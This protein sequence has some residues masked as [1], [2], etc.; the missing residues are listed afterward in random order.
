MREGNILFLT[1]PV[2]WS[3]LGTCNNGVTGNGRCTACEARR[4][5]VYCERSGWRSSLLLDWIQFNVGIVSA[6][7]GIVVLW[8]YHR[9][10]TAVRAERRYLLAN[11]DRIQQF[12]SA[13]RAA[14]VMA[15]VEKKH[16]D[17]E[18]A[19][20]DAA[21]P[22]KT[23]KEIE[24]DDKQISANGS[25]DEPV[26]FFG[27]DAEVQDPTI[28]YDDNDAAVVNVRSPAPKEQPRRTDPFD[29]DVVSSARLFASNSRSRSYDPNMASRAHYRQ[30]QFDTADFGSPFPRHYDSL[31]Q[32]PSLD[33][34]NNHSH[35]VSAVSR[36]CGPGGMAAS[37]LARSSS[38]NH[39]NDVDVSFRRGFESSVASQDHPVSTMKSPSTTSLRPSRPSQHRSLSNEQLVATRSPQ[40]QNS[41][42]TPLR[43]GVD[44]PLGMTTKE[45]LRSPSPMPR[46][47]PGDRVRRNARHV[48]ALCDFGG[49]IGDVL[50]GECVTIE[51]IIVKRDLEK[52]VSYSFTAVGG[53]QEP[54][55]PYTL[56]DLF[57]IASNNSSSNESY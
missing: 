25:D 8:V 37:Q 40:E 3:V 54:P 48:V 15:A 24:K 56:E 6:A 36:G 2:P 30:S 53:D 57:D 13:S 7:M 31:R 27:D 4:Y 23:P 34:D 18:I 39:P 29:L 33:Y 11:S 20:A 32:A 55:V 28:Y 14:Y 42:P 10:F 1:I 26:H 17:E 50:C 44:R 16:R 22:L 19:R 51:T 49:D 46:F 35:G 9:V 52:G 43:S 38:Y 12:A 41:G 21:L 5:G 47:R 45:L